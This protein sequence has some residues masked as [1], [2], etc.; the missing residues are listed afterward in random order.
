MSTRKRVLVLTSTFPRWQGDHEPPFVFELS[1][2]LSEQFDVVVLAPHAPGAKRFEN[3]G[4]LEVHRFRYFFTPWQSL[5]YHGGIMAN[6]KQNRLRYLLVP[7][8]LL[9]EL[10]SLI[11]LLRKYRV[12]VIHAHWLIPNGLVAIVARALDTGEKPDIVCTSHGTDLFGL[13]GF[14]F[15]WLQKQVIL[16]ASRLTVVSAALRAHAIS[17]ASRGDVEVIPMGVDLAVTFTPPVASERSSTALLFVGRLVEKKGVQY[18]IM[19]MPEILKKHPQ[20]MLA[21]AGDGPE[22]ESLRRQAAVL[23]MGKHVRFHGALENAA[24]R[25]LYGNAAIFV[26]PS[27]AEGFG[28]ALVE[29]SG[30]GCPVITTDLAA[31]RDIVIDGVTGLICRRA[32]SADLAA[33]ICFLLEHPELRESMGH[34]G[35]QHVQERFDW[36]TISRQYAALFD[37]LVRERP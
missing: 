28:L 17:L 37:G 19:A 36:G 32:D 9:S 12:D 7:F 13:T 2:R 3:M 26:S 5:A 25:E 21:I 16:E 30:C 18:L 31:I 35:R 14:V 22:R 20:A 10:V 24:L 4:N 1:R 34:A 8:F 27:L 6:L 23:G 15:R 29:A 33:K 11:G